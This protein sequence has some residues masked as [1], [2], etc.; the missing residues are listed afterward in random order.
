MPGIDEKPSGIRFIPLSYNNAES[1]TS[2]MRLLL[3]LKP[4]WEHNGKI[5]FIRF[6]DGITNTLLKAVNKRPGMTEE[7]IDN[8]A[9]LLRAFGKGT[10]LLIDRK[11]EGQNHELLM[12]YGL[13]PK[14]LARFHNGMLYSYLRGNV[15]SP[16]DL[17]KESIYRAVARRLAQWHSVV[18]CLPAVRAPARK[19]TSASE[20]LQAFNSSLSK[21][22]PALQDS[23]DNVAPG[24]VAPN[25][26]TVMQ[27]WIYVLPS[28]TPAEKER[29]AQ[30]QK[31]LL[32][33]VEELSNRPGFG[34]NSVCDPIT[35]HF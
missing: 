19:E 20:A 13:A 8:E 6:T 25:I 26:W 22:G 27:K 9:I 17:R 21:P 29:Q 1:H 2:A 4:E 32:R 12:Q 10:D 11:R 31:E 30:L 24:K 23:I 5:E 7:E 18:P 33:L 14:L 28:A 35:D 15:T 34:K 3:T 16:A